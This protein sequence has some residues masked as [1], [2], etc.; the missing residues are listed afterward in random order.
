MEKHSVL[1]VF[2]P[3]T[4]CIK[5]FLDRSTEITKQFTDAAQINGKP[6]ILYGSPGVGKKTF[7]RNN[8]NQYSSSTLCSY[9]RSE[10]STKDL[11]G[12]VVDSLNEIYTVINGT[13]TGD[14]FCSNIL[15]EYNELKIQI[16]RGL[17]S[18]DK[19]KN[20]TTQLIL[21]KIVNILKDKN[22][23]W[24]I[25]D[26]HKLKT[27]VRRKFIREVRM[28]TTE[29]KQD[30]KI[31]I[32]MNAED[33]N[34][35]LPE[36]DNTITTIKIPPMEKS[37]LE[38]LSSKCEKLLNVSFTD[39]LRNTLLYFAEFSLSIFHELSLNLCLL[40]KITETQQRTNQLTA[41]HFK[42]LIFHYNYIYGN[43]WLNKIYNTFQMKSLI[44]VFL[45]NRNSEGMTI[46]EIYQILNRKILIKYSRLEELIQLL[47]QPKKTKL[48]K[49][50][51]DKYS[52]INVRTEFIMLLKM[53]YDKYIDGKF[54]NG[55]FNKELSLYRNL[56]ENAFIRSIK[57][58]MLN[59][60]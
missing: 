37:E 56:P 18:K 28:L 10:W 58:C 35:I 42:T 57:D 31:I 6:I 24:L 29:L 11:L 47:L 1:E 25:Y 53:Y 36:N 23:C 14:T 33:V 2:T 44:K 50:K 48:L 38:K 27:N 32:V 21:Q 7:I 45:T 16:E 52:I 12:N 4:V 46:N 3:S 43:N 39:E 8:I 19:P 30:I 15:G 51:D 41:V 5:S 55:Q 9:C 60:I 17:N 20:L 54:P 34:T 13:Y 26:F 22:R 49:M 40:T 59:A